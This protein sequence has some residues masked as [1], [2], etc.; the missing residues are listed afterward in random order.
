MGSVPIVAVVSLPSGGA[1]AGARDRYA[2]VLNWM[3]TL[4]VFDVT[5]PASPEIVGESISVGGGSAGCWRDQSVRDSIRKSGTDVTIGAIRYR[6][7]YTLHAWGGTADSS[8]S[9]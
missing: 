4:R 9:A 5:D 7:V 1:A 6:S 3:R 2:Y 8:R